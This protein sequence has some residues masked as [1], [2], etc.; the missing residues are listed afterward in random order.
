MSASSTTAVEPPRGVDAGPLSRPR[1]GVRSLMLDRLATE[2]RSRN[3]FDVLRLIAAML[4]LFAHSFDLLGRPE[5]LG[6]LGWGDVG[7]T[8]FFAISGFLVARS[9][10]LNPRLG[11]FAAKRALRLMPGLIVAVLF[12]ALVLGPIMTS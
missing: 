6:Y 7:V 10:A 3:N 8:I 12:C 11:P 4:V 9:W 1:R 2:G 5:P